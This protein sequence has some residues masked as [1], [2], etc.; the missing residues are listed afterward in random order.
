MFGR[1]FAKYDVVSHTSYFQD[2]YLVFITDIFH[3]GPKGPGGHLGH[4]I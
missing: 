1:I 4:L 3:I 2:D